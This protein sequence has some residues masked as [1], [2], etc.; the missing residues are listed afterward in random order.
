MGIHTKG[1]HGDRES[2][3]KTGIILFEGAAPPLGIRKGE[4]STQVNQGGTNAKKPKNCKASATGPGK[5]VPKR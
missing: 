1:A 5:R 2:D 4:S 3:K